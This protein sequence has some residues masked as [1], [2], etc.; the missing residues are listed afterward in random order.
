MSLT[1]L[2]E[3]NQGTRECMSSEE[4]DQVDDYMIWPQV[5]KELCISG[6]ALCDNEYVG[7]LC[8]FLRRGNKPGQKVRKGGR[9]VLTVRPDQPLCF[10]VWLVRPHITSFLKKSLRDDQRGAFTSIVRA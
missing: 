3:F 6:V 2:A 4:P 7:R 9:D 5:S 1:W 8:E 10:Q